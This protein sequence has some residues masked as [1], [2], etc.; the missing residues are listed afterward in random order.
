M[1]NLFE[2]PCN[3]NFFGEYSA[4]VI[5]LYPLLPFYEAKVGTNYV[6]VQM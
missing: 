5:P 6:I 3:G 1:Q 4:F 2:L